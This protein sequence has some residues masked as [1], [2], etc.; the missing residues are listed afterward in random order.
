MWSEGIKERYVIRCGWDDGG[1]GSTP[2]TTIGCWL[3]R[4]GAGCARSPTFI[5]L[6][7]S[8]ET[9]TLLFWRGGSGLVALGLIIRI[10]IMT[11]NY[12]EVILQG[13]G[14][15]GNNGGLKGK[16]RKNGYLSRQER[17]NKKIYL[18]NDPV[19]SSLVVNNWV[20]KF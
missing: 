5:R 10:F 6:C 1:A 13:G 2:R 8:F 14:C 16:R 15:Y 17:F 9:R 12:V 7:G 20:I 18:K 19:V 4:S 3:W 11:R